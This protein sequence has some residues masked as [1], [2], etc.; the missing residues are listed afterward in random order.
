VRQPLLFDEPAPEVRERDEETLLQGAAAVLDEAFATGAPA[1]LP[2]FSGGHD[3]LS[4]CFVASQHPRFDGRV[5]HI[6]TTIGAAATRAFVTA[7]AAE[8]GWELIVYRSPVSYEDYVREYG[9]PGPG[10]HQWVY[11]RLKERCVRQMLR[12]PGQRLLVTGCRQQESQR[13]MGSVAKIKIGERRKNGRLRDLKRVWTAPCFDWSSAEQR[14]FMD[15]FALPRNPLKEGPLGMS[16]ECN[17]GAFA[18][19]GEIEILKVCAPDV[20]GEI[21]RLERIAAAAGKP[22]VWGARPP[23]EK[24][25]LRL[26]ATGPLCAT[27]DYR[28]A[29]LGLEF[30]PDE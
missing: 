2:L 17:C 12:G 4:A 25:R 21:A 5:H 20:A 6:D 14:R 16:G 13:R 24:G 27:C 11:A 30:E 15:A 28:A 29:T 3:S 10:G 7:T 8:L 26:P 9:F 18:R 1:M 22:A 23:A 19:P